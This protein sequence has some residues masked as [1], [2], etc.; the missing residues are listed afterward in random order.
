MTLL[1]ND[2]QT[3][4]FAYSQAMTGVDVAQA[5][6]IGLACVLTV[7]TP[8]AGTFTANS[9][10]DIFSK[11]THGMKTGLKVQ[12]SNSGGA[13]PSGLSAATDY[14]VIYVAAGTFKLATSLVNAQA[15]TAID[16]S[17]N[18][19]GTQTITPTAIAGASV[20]LQ[21]SQDDSNYFDLGVS[22]NITA[23][24][25]LLLEKVDPSLRYVRAYYTMTAGQISFTQYTIAKG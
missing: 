6:V 1:L 19:T 4:E 14:F 12:V 13:L 7:S 25:N 8:S 18:G 15:G 17:D 9:T 16:I 24:A 22:S 10:T 11:A 23:T 2:S 3:S 20:K 5:K 21:G